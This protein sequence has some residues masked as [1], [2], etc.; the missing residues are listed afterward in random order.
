MNIA[1][2][3][4]SELDQ[5]RTEG[6]TELF[7]SAYMEKDADLK[8]K[9]MTDEYTNA[10]IM[11]LLKYYTNESVSVPAEEDTEIILENMSILELIFE[12]YEITTSEK[13]RVAKDDL[14]HTIG[15]DKT[16]ILNELKQ[17]G[18]V[19]D[20]NCKIVK[21]VELADGNT[22][23]NRVQAFK[24]LKLKPEEHEREPTDDEMNNQ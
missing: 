6:K 17:M 23:K 10:T 1:N 18:C 20:C 24:C 21:S 15:G 19:G 9:V 4:K 11:M 16:K 13:D 7:M 5:M 12:N 14:Y 3:K 8:N 22:S 2:K